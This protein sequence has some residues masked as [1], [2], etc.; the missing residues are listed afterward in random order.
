MNP[1]D[2]WNNRAVN[3]LTVAVV[4]GFA[5]VNFVGS[6]AGRIFGDIFG[7][8]SLGWSWDQF[9]TDLLV[10]AVLLL[11]AWWVNSMSKG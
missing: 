9:W 6:V 2:I 5:V 4:S 8:S 10:F 3:N 11:A 7:S 1:F